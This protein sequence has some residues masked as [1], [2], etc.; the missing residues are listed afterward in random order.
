MGCVRGADAVLALAR[1]ASPRQAQ[2]NWWPHH[3]V[4]I[5]WF[6]RKGAMQMPHSSCLAYWTRA[7]RSTFSQT[8]LTSMLRFLA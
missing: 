2:W 1:H 8:P 5:H 3:V 6:S 4:L 7:T